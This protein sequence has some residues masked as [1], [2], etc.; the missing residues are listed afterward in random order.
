MMG[1]LPPVPAVA[2][3]TFVA[4]FALATLRGVHLGILMFVAAC[5]VGVTLAGMT[6]REVLTGF[7]VSILI[8]VAGVTYFFGIAQLNGT[9]DRVMGGDAGTHWRTFR[10]DAGAVL[11]PGRGGVGQGIAAG[12]AGD[13]AGRACPSARRATRRSSVDGHCHQQRHLRRL[14]RA[15]GLFGIITVWH[16]PAGGIE[17]S[18]FV[19]L[20]VA[21]IADLVL[22][23]GGAGVVS[24]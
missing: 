17:V 3:A 13:G 21:V 24:R 4:V 16:C 23:G 22:L 9:I 8:L 15:H 10:G 12:G 20:A 6:L 1:R 19:L 11:R 2:I 14:V 5:V 7:P 18:T